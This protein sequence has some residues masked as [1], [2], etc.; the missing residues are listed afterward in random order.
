MA[1]KAGGE[2]HTGFSEENL[3]EWDQLKDLRVGGD[4]I[5]KNIG[6]IRQEDFKLI[7]LAHGRNSWQTLVKKKD[8][9]G[10]RIKRG[11]SLD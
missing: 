4:N 2:L 11:K 5:K 1:C 10:G 6:E 9:R 8:E 7:D 3:K